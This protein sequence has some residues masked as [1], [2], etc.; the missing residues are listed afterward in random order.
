MGGGMQ[1]NPRMGGSGYNF[2]TFRVTGVSA[3]KKYGGF[4]S[5]FLANMGR[6]LCD[7]PK[8]DL[9]R[10]DADPCEIQVHLDVTTPYMVRRCRLTPPSG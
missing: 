5:V 2:W 4:L 3:F 8:C 7:S 10:C 1:L 6:D 9:R